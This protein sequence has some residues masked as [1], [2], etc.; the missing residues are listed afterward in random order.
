MPSI[1]AL[2]HTT[3]DAPRLGR[4]LETLYPCAEILVVDHNSS[5]NTLRV[6]REYGARIV[7]VGGK[8]A[9]GNLQP[10]LLQSAAHD[11]IFCIDP[12]EALTEALAASLFEWR[13]LPSKSML[14]NSF[15]IV[16]R[17]ETPTGWQELSAPQT[18]LVP[19]D[20]SRWQDH[21][22]AHDPHAPLLTG[23]LLRFSFP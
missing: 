22:P 3:N 16:L 21:F 1:S 6:A 17:E 14:A 13:G 15:A 5:D 8:N 9:S 2:L 18:R 11:W 4:A 23:E 7:S 12:R 19:R 20:W 10:S